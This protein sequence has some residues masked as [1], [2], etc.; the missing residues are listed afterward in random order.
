MKCLVTGATGFIGGE[1]CRRL[2]ERGVALEKTGREAPTDA[3]LA[4][5][6][7]LYHTAG[8]AH[9]AAAPT[10]YETANHLATLALASRASAAGVDR[11]VFLSSINA[12]PGAEPYGYWKWRTEEELRQ[13][14]AETAMEVVIVRPA[15]VYGPGAKANLRR[16]IDA[17]R[18]GLPAPPPGGQTRSM[19]GLPDLC[20]ALCA[21][22]EVDPGRGSVFHATDGEA[23]D[24]KRIYCAFCTAMGREP[25]RAWL[26]MWAWR[27]GC[28]LL[29]LLR[30]RH[31]GV[32]FGRLFGGT[33]YSNEALCRALAWQPKQQ[34]EDL[35]PAMVEAAA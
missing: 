35:A 11:F 2:G 28:A 9:R 26:P 14:Y 18:R 15:L 30:M 24:L 17:V 13:D 32:T 33:E 34:L 20:D 25:G 3:Q 29:D 5:V 6:T 16:L 22:L 31:P 21:M 10:E 4:G 7:V 19:I 8:I 27:L 23:Y 12:D 1:L